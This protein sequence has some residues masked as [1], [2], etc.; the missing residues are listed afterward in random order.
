MNFERPFSDEQRNAVQE[1]ILEGL[2][3]SDKPS[4]DFTSQGARKRPLRTA[5]LTLDNF[6]DTDDKFNFRCLN[7]FCEYIILMD[8]SDVEHFTKLFE[9]MNGNV[10]FENINIHYGAN[11]IELFIRYDNIDEPEYHDVIYHPALYEFLTLYNEGFISIN[12][13]AEELLNKV[14]EFTKH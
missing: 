8:Y 9:L 5:Y 14:C 12:V 7:T 4:F 2:S 11:V 1:I 13:T 10:A 6:F 3:Y